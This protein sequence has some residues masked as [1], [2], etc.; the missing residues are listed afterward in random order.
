MG[1]FVLDIPGSSPRQQW[2]RP[3]VDLKAEKYIP[4]DHTQF[5][6]TAQGILLLMQS[7]YFLPEISEDEILDRSVSD[8]LA[9]TFVCLQ[10]AYMI[11]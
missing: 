7:G 9:K 5:T 3:H 2:R 10:A 1:E 8:N 4:G 6:L 11:V